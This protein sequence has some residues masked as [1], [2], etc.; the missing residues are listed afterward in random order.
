ME[1]TGT[2]DLSSYIQTLG[3]ED[4]VVFETE[5]G[6]VRQLK[7]RTAAKRGTI[8]QTRHGLPGT[9]G[10]KRVQSVPPYQMHSLGRDMLGWSETCGFLLA[11]AT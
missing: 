5:L 4:A 11:N 7:G 1:S 6:H 3:S 2:N 8:P 10:T 9:F